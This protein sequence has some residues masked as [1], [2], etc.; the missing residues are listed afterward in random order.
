MSVSRDELERVEKKIKSELDPFLDGIRTKKADFELFKQGYSDFTRRFSRAA[1]LFGFL[2]RDMEKTMESQAIEEIYWLFVYLGIIES[3]GNTIVD[4][5]V[6]LLIANGRDFHIERT[7]TR[8]LPRMSHVTSM[9]DLEKERVSLGAKLG[10]LEDNNV[11]ELSSI[12]DSDLRNRIAHLR[13]SFKE[14]RVYIKERPAVLVVWTALVKL[15]R[16]LRVTS[17]LISQLAEAKGLTPKVKI[18]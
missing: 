16:A 2:T 4:M 11:K 10:F 15:T 5:I 3:L 7:R 9:K 18:K 6:I 14:K 12:I 13:F 1:E 8:K 17:N